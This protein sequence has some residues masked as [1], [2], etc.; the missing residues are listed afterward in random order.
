MVTIHQFK[1][2]H[3]LPEATAA[4]KTLRGRG[5]R[6]NRS[7]RFEK[8]DRLLF[9]DGWE[10]LDE[11][12]KLKTE[13]TEER[14]KKI[15]TKNKSLDLGFEQ[16]INPYRGCEHGCSYC[17]ARPTHA[18]MGLSPGLD[19][20]SKLF[21]KLNAAELLRKELSAPG[22]EPKAIVLG[23]NTDPYQP[24]ERRYRVTRQI[25]EVLQEFNHPVGIV[26]KSAVVL[27][28]LDILQ[29][30]AEQNLVKV[31]ISVT[32]MKPEIAR[33][34]E[35]RAA[36]PTKRLQALEVLSASGVPTCVMV[37]PI[38]PAINDTEIEEILNA[39]SV[40][41]TREAGYV[42]LRLPLELR[43]LF[44]E[45]LADEFPDAAS[46]CMSL[47]KSTRKGKDYD[48]T[49]GQRMTG[50]GPYAWSI[51]RR[52]EITAKRLGFNEKR[53][54]LTRNLFI[55]PPQSGE[56]LQLF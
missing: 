54:K 24:I 9:D 16:S 2:H 29:P 7:G 5:A 35:P 23:T 55:R 18:F 3:K 43:E 52:F 17:Y 34:M 51:G 32:T 53:L 12:P 44:R 47:L 1:Q 49:W 15:I 31:A 13:V 21:V 42:M 11:L 27:R 4:P 41:G 22:Y 14:P 6:S 33:K 48:S 37:A 30:M 26:T 50:T 20:E 8:N 28:D 19:F 40:T 46:R 45:W 36:S 10:T 25:L 56:Q 39:A 38:V